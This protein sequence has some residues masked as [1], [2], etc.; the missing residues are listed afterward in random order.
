MR[1]CKLCC[2]YDRLKTSKE[3]PHALHAIEKSQRT[4]R[5]NPLFFPIPLIHNLYGGIVIKIHLLSTYNGSSRCTKR[6]KLYIYDDTAITL[7]HHHTLNFTLADLETWLRNFVPTQFRCST[8]HKT[9]T[10]SVTYI[11]CLVCQSM[12]W[13]ITIS[14]PTPR[15]LPCDVASLSLSRGGGKGGAGK[16][17]ISFR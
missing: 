4:R 6:Q 16:A 15:A 5:K 3:T 9:H 12:T 14:F 10:A 1:R 17:R 8:R 7:D 11:F 2:V 13:I